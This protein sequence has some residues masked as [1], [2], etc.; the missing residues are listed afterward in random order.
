VI[1]FCGWKATAASMAIGSMVVKTLA[2]PE[3][4]LLAPL[5]ITFALLAIEMLFRM[6]RLRAGEVGPR[7]DA[8][9][10]V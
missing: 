5:Q 10:A 6:Q 3:W 8:V 4:W 1:A 2:L 7:E 9:T